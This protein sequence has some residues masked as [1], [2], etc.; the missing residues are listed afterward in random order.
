MNAFSQNHESGN[1]QMGCEAIAPLLD[2]YHDN[3]MNDAERSTVEKHLANC[4]ACV[5]E[6][7]NIANL[8]HTLGSLP[9]LETD[10]DFAERVEQHIRANQN[11]AAIINKSQSVVPISKTRRWFAVA[12]AV[13]ILGLAGFQ[14]AHHAGQTVSVAS[15]QLPETQMTT[16]KSTTEQTQAAPEINQKSN[17]VA[18]TNP[19]QNNINEELGI[20]TDE[21]GLYA[22]KM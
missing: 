12:A 5:A 1:N 11:V 13:A 19:V 3:E 15:S 14:I 7:E 16:E 8:V 4:P 18:I 2:C 22:I 6:L 17:L 21:D 10:I 20:K 9:P